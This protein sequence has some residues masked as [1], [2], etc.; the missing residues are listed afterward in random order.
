MQKVPTVQ[1]TYTATQA[2]R[3]CHLKDIISKAD[4]VRQFEGDICLIRD[5]Q[6]VHKSLQT[7]QTHS[8]IKVLYILYQTWPTH[9]S[10]ATCGSLP[11]FMRL[12]HSCPILYLCFFLRNM[13]LTCM[14]IDSNDL[15]GKP[16]EWCSPSL[17][18]NALAKSQRA[19]HRHCP[20]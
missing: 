20:E 11:I 5:P 6:V 13:Y 17:L 19:S 9:I 2:E 3:Q 4:D 15:E 14:D 18:F 16:I 7:R 1:K 10:R 12:L 8:V